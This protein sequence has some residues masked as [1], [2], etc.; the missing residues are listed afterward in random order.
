MS[1]SSKGIFILVVCFFVVGA[2]SFAGAKGESASSDL[3]ETITCDL[4]TAQPESNMTGQVAKKFKE[5][6]EESSDGSITVNLFLGGAMGGAEDV[7]AAVT[8]GAVQA[9]VGGP[10]P[11]NLYAPNFMF[12]ANPLVMRD[13]DHYLSVWNSPIGDRLRSAVEAGGKYR[14]IAPVYVGVRHFTSNKPAK[15]AE[16]L[17]GIKTRIPVIQSWIDVWEEIGVSVAPLP[18]DELYTSL[19][20]GVVD[21]SEGEASHCMS[22]KL[23]EVQDYYCLT[24]HLVQ[25]CFLGFNSDWYNGLSSEAREIVTKAAK[26]ACDWGSQVTIETEQATIE[27]LDQL[28]MKTVEV[29]KESIRNA[30]MP[31]VQ[32][33][34]ERDY[35][36]ISLEEIN[37]Y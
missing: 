21:A 29:D 20:T 3:Q 23:Y 36:G 28:G 24:G 14:L 12:I 37:S 2:L 31:A 7:T 10:E 19:A 34:F 6:V 32:K 35:R 27:K 30:G 33:I 18:L 26:D 11:I 25:V 13:F 22:F 17:K 16:E 5:L 1:N 9:Q 15:T 4:A 8:S